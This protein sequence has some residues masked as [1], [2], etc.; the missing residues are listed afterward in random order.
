MICIKDQF[1]FSKH[2]SSRFCTIVEIIHNNSWSCTHRQV[3]EVAR[4][5]RVLLT[6][7]LF[8]DLHCAAVERLRLLVLAL[9]S[10]KLLLAATRGLECALL[11]S[12]TSFSHTCARAGVACG[13][14]IH[15]HSARNRLCKA[16]PMIHLRLQIPQDQNFPHR[17]VLLQTTFFARN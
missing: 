13:H 8:L 6:K 17:R 9:C 4:D 11:G 3:V 2:I 12:M 16:R 14:I 15:A 1:S 7:Y 5:I 10:E